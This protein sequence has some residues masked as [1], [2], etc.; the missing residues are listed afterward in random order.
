[1]TTKLH[2]WRSLAMLVTLLS[3]PAS[4]CADAVSDWNAIA[5]QATVTASRPGQTGMLDV[6][7]VHVAIYDAVQAIEKRYEPYYVDLGKHDD[8]RDDNEPHDQR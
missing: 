5:V 3:A 2:G 1:M 7:M 4:V 8:G 6:A